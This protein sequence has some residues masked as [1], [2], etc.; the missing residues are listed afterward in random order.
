M[1]KSFVIHSIQYDII[2]ILV[3]RFTIRHRPLTTVCAQKPTQNSLRSEVSVARCTPIKIPRTI[4][5]NL[6]KPGTRHSPTFT[7]RARRGA[8]RVSLSAGFFYSDSEA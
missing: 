6:Q 2:L 1:F 4:N 3:F 8:A 5:Q 7:H